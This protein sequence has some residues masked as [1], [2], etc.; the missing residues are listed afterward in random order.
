MN[1]RIGKSVFGAITI[2]GQSYDHDVVIRLN[3]AVEKRKKHLSVAHFGTSHM[4]S[5]EEAEELYEDGARLIIIGS[6]QS[7]MVQLSPEAAA[8][9]QDKHCDVQ[10]LPTPEAVLCW[11]NAEGAVIGLFHLTC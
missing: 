8:F 11:N 2:D 7:G 4:I 1:A 9:F 10:L 3:G 6:G 5:L